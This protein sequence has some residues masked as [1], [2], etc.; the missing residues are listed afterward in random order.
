M[1]RFSLPL[2][3]ASVLLAVAACLSLNPQPANN[4]SLVAQSVA[5]LA[6]TPTVTIGPRGT[7]TVLASNYDGWWDMTSYDNGEY[8][9]S[10]RTSR[11]PAVAIV[12]SRDCGLHQG[13]LDV[14]TRRALAWGCIE[15]LNLTPGVATGTEYWGID[16][17]PNPNAQFI[18][19]P[20]PQPTATPTP[21]SVST[22]T[23]TP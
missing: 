21:T 8:F 22:A 12:G 6:T 1:K 10:V 7:P 2:L 14:S 11:A 17:N 20:T 9:I 18:L 3:L 4:V 15:T 13:A 5:V 19:T 16:G 23:P